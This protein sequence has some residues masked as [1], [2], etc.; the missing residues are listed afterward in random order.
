MTTRRLTALLLGALLTSGLHAAETVSSS[1]GMAFPSVQ[2]STS[3]RAIGLG[4]TYVGIAEGSAALLWNPA[5][6]GGLLCPEIALH[7]KSGLLG[8][9][10]ETAVLGLPLGVGNGLGISL[11]YGD[12]GDFEGRDILG[13]LTGSYSARAYG[14]SLGWGF[15]HSDFGLGLAVKYNQQALAGSS[16]SAFAGDLGLLW[17]PSEYFNLGAAYSNF[18]PD[19]S[20]H[21][22]AQGL[23][24]G[25]SS[26]LG[27]GS[28]LQW[29]LAV[30]GESLKDSDNSVHLGLESSLFKTLALRAGYAFDVPKPAEANGLSGWTFG[31]GITLESLSLD[32][33]FVPLG[34]IGNTQR[35]SLTYGFGGC[36]DRP[37]PKPAPTPAPQA[38]AKPAPVPVAAAT[39]AQTPVVEAV[40]IEQETKSYTV[41]KGDTLWSISDKDRMRGDSFQWPLIHDE[42]AGKV[43]NPDKIY[44]NQKL[45]YHDDYTKTEIKDARQTAKD[46]PAK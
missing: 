6:L 5:G 18:G 46:T 2:E 23:R 25:L 9:Y 24:V 28:D 32:Y 4:S 16:T 27:K 20:G 44:P 1:A 14:G 3:A 12:N 43:T 8:A 39:P 19:V 7:H 45:K 34:D 38:K 21:P 37:K 10:Q 33:A 36:A 15:K 26:Y 29:L 13:N 35:V 11:N 42:N 31:G 22:L 17:N 41:K 40:V 30:S